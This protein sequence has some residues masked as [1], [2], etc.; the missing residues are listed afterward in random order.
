MRYLDACLTTA[1]LYQC[2]HIP[3]TAAQ[4]LSG[5][6]DI[7]GTW[8]VMYADSDDQTDPL[9]PLPHICSWILQ[10]FK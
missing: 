7:M 6:T 2:L 3:H 8:E 1:A 4:G 5:A 9:F 10:S